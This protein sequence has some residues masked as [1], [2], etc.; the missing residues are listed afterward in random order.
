MADVLTKAEARIDE[1]ML[2]PDAGIDDSG[3][4]LLKPQIDLDQHVVVARIIL[5]HL[6]RALV[7]HQHDR[8]VQRRRNPGGPAVVGQR[9][10]V[11]DHPS[12]GFDRRRHDVGF[13]R[14]A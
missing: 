9:G 6:R 1:N 4:T 2:A 13:A 11:V 5:H 3:D 12:A 8:H 10:Y 7:M 14:V